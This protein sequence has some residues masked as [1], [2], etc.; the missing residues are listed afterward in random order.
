MNLLKSRTKM[1]RRSR[2]CAAKAAGAS[3]GATIAGAATK[4]ARLGWLLPY[5]SWFSI[6]PLPFV[7]WYYARLESRNFRDANVAQLQWFHDIG[8][9]DALDRE[10]LIRHI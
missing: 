9:L 1:R 10:A 6:L 3:T 2:Q 7:S 5:I 8:C 4:F